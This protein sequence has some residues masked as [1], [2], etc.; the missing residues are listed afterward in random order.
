MPLGFI[1][2]HVDLGRGGFGLGGSG[3]AIRDMA[4]DC[5]D[6][7]EGLDLSDKAAAGDFGAYVA[8]FPEA[9]QDL[10]AAHVEGVGVCCALADGFRGMA[11]GHGSREDRVGEIDLLAGDGV[12][13]FMFGHRWLRW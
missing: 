11:V 8:D 4:F 13:C 9:V 3:T 10:A 5:D 7:G 2:V 1:D 12:G 6:H